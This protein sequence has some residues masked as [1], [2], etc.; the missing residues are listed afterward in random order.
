VNHNPIYVALDL[1]RLDAA[2][3]LAR[4]IKATGGIKLGLEFFCARPSRRA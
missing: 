4:R 3:A 2:E 1:P